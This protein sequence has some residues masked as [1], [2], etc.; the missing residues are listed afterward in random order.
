MTTGNDERDTMIR[1]AI[2]E[3]LM[4]RQSPSLGLVIDKLPR[5]FDLLESELTDALADMRTAGGGELP[6]FES[7]TESFHNN[8]VSPEP[9][10][11]TPRADHPH[12]APDKITRE[13]SQ[14]RVDAAHVRHGEAV[15]AVR[16]AQ[17]KVH[18]AQGVLAHA[19]EAW[20][21]GT[22]PRTQAEREQ[23]NI[24]DHLRS[25]QEKRAARGKPASTATIFVQRQMRNGPNRGAFS[26]QQAARLGF[27][28]PRSKQ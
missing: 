8:P 12:S 15:V 14:A 9:A 28:D 18:N 1:R 10:D 17:Q 16:I 2:G 25:E 23:A 7:P 4:L 21:R 24:R 6:E 19:I 11:T 22:D 3:C 26:M 13:Q 27:R 5:D 20:Q